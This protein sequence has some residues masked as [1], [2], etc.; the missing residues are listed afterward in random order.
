METTWPRVDLHNEP[1]DLHIRPRTHQLYLHLIA[2]CL[3]DVRATD[4]IRSVGQAT[5]PA[6]S[7]AP[8]PADRRS[9]TIFRAPSSFSFARNY[10]PLFWEQRRVSFDRVVQFFPSCVFL[11]SFH[12]YLDSQRNIFQYRLLLSTCSFLSDQNY[13][14][15]YKIRRSILHHQIISLIFPLLKTTFFFLRITNT[16]DPYETSTIIYYNI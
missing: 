15:Y 5:A 14:L 9:S 11:F 12:L 2:G 13:Q 7:S 1:G 16:T 4:G 6:L 8:T 10:V 3:F